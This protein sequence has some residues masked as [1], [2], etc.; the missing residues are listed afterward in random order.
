MEDLTALASKIGE[1]VLEAESFESCVKRQAGLMVTV[2]VAD[3]SKAAWKSIYKTSSLVEFFSS[4]LS[5]I[6]LEAR[7]QVLA[8]MGSEYT[9]EVAAQ[10]K[11]TN[12]SEL[13]AY[14]NGFC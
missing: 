3:V 14:V 2:E 9:P 5:Q 13:Q 11:I 8:L 1:E 4:Q 12:V 10:I 7:G 6:Y